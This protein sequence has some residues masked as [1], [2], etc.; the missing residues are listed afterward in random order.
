MV[1]RSC[2]R[3]LITNQSNTIVPLLA[4]LVGPLR[5]MC[6]SIKILLIAISLRFNTD[7]EASVS[8]RNTNHVTYC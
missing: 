2:I 7:C 4:W 3:K 1:K 6:E 5:R 8:N